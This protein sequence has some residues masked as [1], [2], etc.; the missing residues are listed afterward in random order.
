M[1]HRSFGYGKRRSRSDHKRIIDLIWINSVKTGVGIYHEAMNALDI[2][3]G[4]IKHHAACNPVGGKINDIVEI[5]QFRKPVGTQ[6]CL[7]K[8]KNRIFRADF[9]ILKTRAGKT[10]DIYAETYVATSE[11]DI[12]DIDY[13]VMAVINHETARRCRLIGKNHTKLKRIDRK[14]WLR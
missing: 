8:H 14:F 4:G 7:H 10:V 2:L 5:S 6:S 1:Q 11:S 12:T 3:P 13:L 9:N